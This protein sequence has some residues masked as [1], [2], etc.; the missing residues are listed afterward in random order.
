MRA[1][2]VEQVVGGFLVNSVDEE[3]GEQRDGEGQGDAV[4]LRDPRSS[5]KAVRQKAQLKRLCS[6]ARSVGNKEEELETAMHLKS[7]DLVAIAVEHA[8]VS[9]APS[10]DGRPAGTGR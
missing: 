1:T 2:G 9:W 6:N 3:G 7:S 5:S 4:A 10:E 8:L